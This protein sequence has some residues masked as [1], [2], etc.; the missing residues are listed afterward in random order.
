MRRRTARA[1]RC[2]MEGHEWDEGSFVNADTKRNQALAMRGE[3][4][5]VR[6]LATFRRCVRCGRSEVKRRKGERGWTR[7]LLQRNERGQVFR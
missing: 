5:L 2:I 1:L 6:R 3:T 4:H 7:W